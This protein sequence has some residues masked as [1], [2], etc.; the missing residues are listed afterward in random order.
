VRPS[1][2]KFGEATFAVLNIT[3][4]CQTYSLN[5]SLS[6]STDLLIYTGEKKLNAARAAEP[7][8]WITR[9]LFWDTLCRSAFVSGLAL[10]SLTQSPAAHGVLFR[11]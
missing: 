2:P 1:P 7:T 3:I 9:A 6:N 4:L 5:G 8:T 11:P 10:E